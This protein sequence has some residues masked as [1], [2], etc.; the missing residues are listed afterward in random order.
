MIIQPLS[1]SPLDYNGNLGDVRTNTSCLN[2]IKDN[3]IYSFIGGTNSPTD[4]TGEYNWILNVYTDHTYVIQ[5]TER[6]NIKNNTRIIF[7]RTYGTQ[8][9]DWTENT[10]T[11]NNQSITS[12]LQE[13]G[14]NINMI[15]N[16]ITGDN[17]HTSTIIMASESMDDWIMTDGYW[18][19]SFI[20]TGGK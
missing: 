4:T 11:F 14:D 9:S 13:Y 5:V 6:T 19:N 1:N 20:S 12:V 16:S 17:G 8:W 18:G 15:L 7:T 2:N 10:Q 3:G